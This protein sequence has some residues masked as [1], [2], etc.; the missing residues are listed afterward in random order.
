LMGG[1]GSPMQGI[2]G[3][4]TAEDNKKLEEEFLKEFSYI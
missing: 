2:V 3:K 4:F 1:F